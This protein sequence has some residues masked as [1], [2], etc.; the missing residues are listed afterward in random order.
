MTKNELLAELYKSHK[1]WVGLAV[2]F[3]GSNM[4]AEDL[5]QE[6]Y[7]KIHRSLKDVNK[8]LNEDNGIRFGYFY[9]TL[10]S[11]CIDYKR[12]KGKQ[13]IVEYD[14]VVYSYQVLDAF[15][16]KENYAFQNLMD[17][18]DKE[19]KQWHRYD[20]MFTDIYYKT[21]ISLRGLEKESKFI[22]ED[23]N[24][25]KGISLTSLYN[26]SKNCKRRLRD[27]FDEDAQDY[28]NGDY[29]KLL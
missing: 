7:L 23:G 21:D 11:V 5:V 10:F 4:F 19:I 15:D 17:S 13:P 6:A 22:D 28:F 1:K 14:E 27:K 12:V 18:I 8:I 3:V 20:I 9:S 2:K 16:I 26:T 29:D 25:Y 24:Q